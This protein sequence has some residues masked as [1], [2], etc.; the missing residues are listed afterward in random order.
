MTQTVLSLSRRHVLGDLYHRCDTISG[1][2]PVYLAGEDAPI[3]LGHANESLGYYAD[4]FSFHL[5]ANECK[6]LSAGNF[7]FSVDYELSNPAEAGS[8]GRVR[9][10]A[11]TLTG[12]KS[13]EKPVGARSVLAEG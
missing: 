5:D 4:A 6:K 9:L 10:T 1:D 7:A 12:R 11:I 8:R 3:L 13:Y 2:I